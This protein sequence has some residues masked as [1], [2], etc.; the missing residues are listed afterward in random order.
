MKNSYEMKPYN[1]ALK[2]A[3]ANIKLALVKLYNHYEEN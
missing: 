1:A 2:S 3:L